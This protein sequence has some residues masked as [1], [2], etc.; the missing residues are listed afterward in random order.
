MTSK[1]L[2]TN[3]IIALSTSSKSHIRL[4]KRQKMSS[5]CPATTRKFA[6]FNSP[7]SHF[8]LFQRP[9][10]I[11]RCYEIPW[12]I[13]LSTSTKSNIGMVKRPKMSSK[14]HASPW[15]IAFSTSPNLVEYEKAMF[16]GLPCNFLLIFGLLNIAKCE[17]VEVETPCSRSHMALLFYFRPLNQPKLRIGRSKK[18]NFLV[19]ARQWEFIFCVLTSPKCDFD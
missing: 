12:N 7:K 10:K 13:G 5:Q 3:W 11:C 9:K 14:W 1:C 2:S 16:Q 17:L 15:N 8:R 6:S 19:V 18:V 4:V